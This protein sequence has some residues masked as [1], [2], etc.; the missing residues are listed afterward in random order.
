MTLVATRSPRLNGDDAASGSTLTA[1]GNYFKLIG[2]ILDLSKQLKIAGV[3]VEFAREE[4]KANNQ[5]GIHVSMCALRIAAEEICKLT[6][7]VDEKIGVD[8]DDATLAY[9]ENQ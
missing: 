1:G 4:A 7:A 2:S 6:R 9:G 3:A 8:M 5:A